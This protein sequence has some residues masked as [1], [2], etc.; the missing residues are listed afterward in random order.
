MVTKINSIIVKAGIVLAI[1]AFTVLAMP[2]GGF[3]PH[4][5]PGGGPG[6]A[7][8]L[9][10][11]PDLTEKQEKEIYAILDPV[12]TELRKAQREIGDLHKEIQELTLE[13]ADE[14]I[15]NRKIDELAD[16]QRVLMKKRFALHRQIAQVLTEE[17]KKFLAE[18]RDQIPGRKRGRK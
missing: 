3:G 13:G 11:I 7:G 8:M 9:D 16:L 12:R 2:G 5:R 14:A 15:V 4:G 1:S 6:I 10:R 17:Q 18:K